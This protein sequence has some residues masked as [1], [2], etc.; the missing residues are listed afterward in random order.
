MQTLGLDL[1]FF[2]PTSPRFASV[3]K[4]QDDRYIPYIMN[5]SMQM[6]G[7]CKSDITTL[8][9][10]LHLARRI[11]SSKLQYLSNVFML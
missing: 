7:K 11:I 9:V 10:T 1:A 6:K 2:Y 8:T 5:S 3:M 4:R